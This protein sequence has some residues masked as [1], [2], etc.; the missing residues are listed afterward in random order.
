MFCPRPY[1]YQMVVSEFESSSMDSNSVFCLLDC[2][3]SDV[4]TD[5]GKMLLEH[6][7]YNPT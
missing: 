5:A 2:N 1:D 4:A 6:F 3:T 7:T